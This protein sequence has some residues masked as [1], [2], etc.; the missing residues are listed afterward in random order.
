MAV[1]YEKSVFKSSVKKGAILTVFSIFCLA[2]LCT[3][4]TAVAQADDPQNPM[5][6]RVGIYDNPPKVFIDENGSAR[7]F[8]PDIVNYIAEQEGWAVEYIHGTWEQSLEK[9]ENHEIDLMVDVA[10]TDERK[11]KFVFTNQTILLSWTE[12]YVAQTADIQTFT[13]LEN[14][15]IGVLT[16]SA[17]YSGEG[18]IREVLDDFDI[19]ANFIEFDSYG[20]VFEA[21]FNQS[22]DAGVTNMIYGAGNSEKYGLKRTP[23]IFRPSELAFAMP[24]GAEK[25]ETLIK[26]IDY[27]VALLK[28]DRGSIY[29]KSMARY[30]F[31]VVEKPA[32]ELTEEEKEWLARHTDIRLG[33]NPDRPP[34]EFIDNLGAYRGIGADYAAKISGLLEISMSPARGLAWAEALKKGKNKELDVFPAIG[35]TF[36]KSAY[37]L[38]T[39][40]YAK[41]PVVLVAK[42]DAPLIGDLNEFPGMKVAVAE[43]YVTHG[44]MEEGYPSIELVYVDS[45]EQGLRAVENGRADAFAGNVLTINHELQKLGLEDF[46]V[47]FITPYTV[48]LR[49][50]VRDD[51]PELVQILDKVLKAISDQEKEAI[52]DKWAAAFVSRG[53]DWGLARKILLA[54]AVGAAVIIALILF[55][56]RSLK[57]IVDTRTKELQTSQKKLQ[58][59]N[60]RLEDGIR[61]REKTEEALR[62]SNKRLSELDKL[63][64][65]FLNITSH[66]LKTPLIPIRAQAEL[67]LAGDYGKLNKEQAEAVDMIFKN[68]EIMNKLVNDVLDITKI[69]S[70]K[71]SL[72]LEK[73][74]IDG[75]VIDAV[76]GMEPAAK[77][78]NIALKLEPVPKLPKIAVDQRRMSQVMG[79]LLDNAIKFTPAKGKVV[80]SVKKT[81]KDI[82]VS[83]KDTGMGMSEKIMEKLFTPFFQGD[84]AITRLYGG[85]GLGL[86]ICKGIIEAHGG[87]IRAQSEGRGKGSTFT[88]TIPIKKD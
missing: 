53:F 78:K 25:N 27:H 41:I 69:K 62:A 34:F 48:D 49:F 81:A 19:Q 17:N 5:T 65:D 88:F 77:E 13:D 68:E 16:G 28:E 64:D 51:W 85:T 22:V 50:A 4:I 79:N 72:T 76:R 66:E 63:K 84:T 70:R 3:P 31:G 20:E 29:N 87:K 54:V 6:V 82:S 46:K 14:K 57:K 80:V 47:A 43:G 9:L 61:S 11:E 86:S 83:I 26:A 37:L 67:L 74:S 39:E 18:G 73:I 45:T 7:G 12:I 59:I 40:P 33:I 23:I 42:S 2:L 10:V 35:R 60:K 44:Y 32:L 71:L 21:V 38:F 56:N 36:E 1:G 30:F 58:T 75:V 15:N 52:L 55:W 8:W 24:K